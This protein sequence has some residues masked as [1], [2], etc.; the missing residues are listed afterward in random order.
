MLNPITTW[1]LSLMTFL[2]PPDKLAAL[3]QYP[4]WEETAEDKFAR[5]TE[6]AEALYHVT[7]DRKTKSLFV[8]PRGRARTAATLL[9]LAFV[10]SG[11]A[12]DV[13]K[14]P[15]SKK[16]PKGM[17]CD[18]GR[19]AGLAQIELG[20]E[21]TM[22][23]RHGVEGKTKA[24]IFGNRELMFGIELVLV[25]RSYQSCAKYGPDW[26]LN[27][28]AS[29]SCTRAKSNQQIAGTGI[30]AGK[31]VPMPDGYLKGKARLDQARRLLNRM[32]VPGPDSEYLWPL[33]ATGD[34]HPLASNER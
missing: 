19:A 11:F 13:D 31:M 18:G 15:C 21:T 27:S 14:G 23:E 33:E 24:D 7:Y 6:I 2:A 32:P 3:P 17:D 5:Y 26:A 1:L 22:L 10:E 28:Y 12:K 9:A 16:R 34:G 29:G 20:D 4:G 30:F 8:G 25:R